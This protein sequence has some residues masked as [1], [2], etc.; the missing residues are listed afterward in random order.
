[1]QNFDLIVLMLYKL[2]CFCITLYPLLVI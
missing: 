1:M 2:K